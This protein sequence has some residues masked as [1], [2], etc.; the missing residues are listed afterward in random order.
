M[1]WVAAA[2]DSSTAYLQ[3]HGIARLLVLRAPRPPPPGVRP[4]TLFRARGSIYGTKDA[5]RS[6][7]IKLLHDA[8]ECGWILS[9]IELA[10]FYLYDESTFPPT[11]I[12]V[13]A[14]HVDDLITC[15]FG[16]KYEDCMK[17]LTKRLHLKKK[18]TEFRFCGKNLIQHADKS[19]SL[20]QVDA[21]EGLEYQTLDKHRRKFPNLPLSEEEKSEFRA[22]IG[23]MGWIA[24]QTR[25]DVMVNVSI[26]SQSIGHPCI[27]NVIDLNK[28]VKMLKDS[29]DAQWC[30]KPSNLTLE[31]CAVF[32]CADSSFANTEGLRSQC[33]VTW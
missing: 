23:S 7:W 33:V 19:I 22:L 16:E 28:A 17:E 15:G 1:G 4:G 3:S 13:M 25:P 12:G 11:L 14:S 20:E 8:K 29:A 30:F 32:V 6:W 9:Q 27:K 5:G 18:D 24:R 10:L 21:I 26:A 2:Y 31:N